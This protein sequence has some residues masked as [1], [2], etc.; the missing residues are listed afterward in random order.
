LP[1]STQPVVHNEIRINSREIAA[2][3][4]THEQFITLMLANIKSPHKQVKAGNFTA[5]HTAKNNLKTSRGK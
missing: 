4:V 5:Y 1:L 2:G 3:T